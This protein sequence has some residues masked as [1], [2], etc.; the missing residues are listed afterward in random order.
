MPDYKYRAAL[1]DGKI[2]RGKMVAV[3]KSQVITKLKMSKIQPISIKRM[4][5]TRKKVSKS[6]FDTFKNGIQIKN[7]APKL[8]I[9][10]VSFSDLKNI[11]FHPFRRVSSKDLIIFSNTLYIL[12]K[13]RFNNIQALQSLFEGTE[14]PAFKDVV[15]DILIGVEAGERLNAVMANYPKVF[16]P[17]YVNFIKVGE[18]SGSLDVALLHARDY[19]ESSLKLKKQIRSTIIPRSLQFI[20]IMIALFVSLL[21][22]VPLIQNVYDMFGSKQKLPAATLIAVDITK[23]MLANWYILVLLIVVLVLGFII[24]INTAR[25]RYLWDRFLLKIPVL[26]NLN[27]NIMVNKF[28]LA[29]LLNLKN[30]MRIQES[31]EISKNVTGNYY[32]LSIVE[33]G[34]SNSLS[35]GSWIEPFGEHGLFKPMVIEM[36]NIGMKTDLTEMMEKVNE[37]IKMEIDESIA[38][39]VK[40][41]PEITYLFVGIALIAFMITVMVPLINVYMGG[42]LM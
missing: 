7:Q 1:R 5:E 16:P 39:F 9:S 2:V 34:K 38:R 12:K 19:L 23:W 14:N 3:N 31:L 28:F 11:D 8:D 21:I 6:H 33:V 15:E 20:G 41:L 42:F 35:G 17:M 40:F 13:A 32:F 25:G 26:G 30:G 22:G 37:Y 24:Y 10:K 27:K 18:E 4:K 29:M 36:L